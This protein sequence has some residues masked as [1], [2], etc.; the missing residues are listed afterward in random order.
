MQI[1][2]NR[3][4]KLLNPFTRYIVFHTESANS[5]ERENS[6]RQSVAYA[7]STPSERISGFDMCSTISS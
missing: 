5:G 2:R 4:T 1:R 3:A 7:A 6:T